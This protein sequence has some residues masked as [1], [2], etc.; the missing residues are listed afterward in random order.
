[1]NS[2]TI[3]INFYINNKR[4]PFIH[5]EFMVYRV[6]TTLENRF[7]AFVNDGLFPL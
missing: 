7:K 5:K 2:R 1:M 6:N 4:Y 3:S